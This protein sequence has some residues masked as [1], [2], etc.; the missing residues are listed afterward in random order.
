MKIG[1]KNRNSIIRINQNKQRLQKK[2][3]ILSHT[4]YLHTQKIKSKILITCYKKAWKIS[5]NSESDHKGDSITYL[6]MY[7]AL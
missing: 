6:I 2:K 4:N 1:R 3:D 7:C 5:I